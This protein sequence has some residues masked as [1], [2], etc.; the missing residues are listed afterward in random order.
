MADKKT[1]ESI[2]TKE[3]STLLKHS[4]LPIV[5]RIEGRKRTFDYDPH[6]DGSYVR[7]SR[8]GHCVTFKYLPSENSIEVFS[9]YDGDYSNDKKEFSFRN[10]PE[11]LTYATRGHGVKIEQIHNKL[12]KQYHKNKGVDDEQIRWLLMQKMAEIYI[13][14]KTKK[15]KNDNN[16]K[17]LS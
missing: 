9:S 10:L 4:R 3:I 11:S 5:V 1:I 2:I 13:S 14:G 8:I 7:R 16:N 12:F 17:K 6:G 15:Y